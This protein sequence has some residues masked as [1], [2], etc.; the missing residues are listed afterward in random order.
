[1]IIKDLQNLDLSSVGEELDIA[2][3]KIIDLKQ[4]IKRQGGYNF[5]KMALASVQKS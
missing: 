4:D 2:M 5:P 3:M 1:M